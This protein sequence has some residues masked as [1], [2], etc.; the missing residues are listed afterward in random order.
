M[1][2]VFIFF[3]M[4]ISVAVT[5][6]ETNN[7]LIDFKVKDQNDSIIDFAKVELINERGVSVKTIVNAN[8]KGTRYSLILDFDHKYSML[9][10]AEGF[11]SKTI[12]IDTWQ[13]PEEDQTWGYEYGGFIFDLL[14][15]SEHDEKATIG[16]I[17]YDDKIELFRLEK[18]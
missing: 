15:I 14:P 17:Y 2:A 3:L 11:H 4:A 13:V 16:R 8:E 1:K 10:S 12:L 9:I 18:F 7:L 5:A 6:Q